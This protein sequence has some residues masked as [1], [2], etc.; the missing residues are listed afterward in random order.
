M[1]EEN[2]LF[3]AAYDAHVLAAVSGHLAVYPFQNP[4]QDENYPPQGKGDKG[5]KKR[6]LSFEHHGH[7]NSLKNSDG[8]GTPGPRRRIT[9]RISYAA[10]ARKP[11]NVTHAINMG[12]SEL[13]VSYEVLNSMPTFCFPGNTCSHIV[14]VHS[15]EIVHDAFVVG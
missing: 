11:T 15:V 14:K 13:P 8:T 9:R 10:M 5:Q 1:V 7:S 6:L 4:R 2:N 3:S 12:P